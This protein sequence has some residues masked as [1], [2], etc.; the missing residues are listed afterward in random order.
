MSEE[1]QNPEISVS[2]IS[3]SHDKQEILRECE[4]LVIYI[5]R[6]GDVLEN[7]Y[8]KNKGYF[9]HLNSLVSKCQNNDITAE[10]WE[11]LI[12][13]YANTSN[14]TYRQRSVNGRTVLDTL[15]S[16]EGKPGK[17]WDIRRWIPLLFYPRRYERPFT[18][19]L[20]LLLAAFILQYSVGWAGRISDPNLLSSNLQ[21][22]FNLVNDLVPLLLPAVWGGIGSCDFLMKR[23]SD[24]LFNYAYE[25][26]RL[27]GDGTRILLG[28]IF[29]ILVVQIF[30][31][32]NDDNLAI[33]EIGLA[34]MTTAFVTGLGVK[35]VYGAFEAVVEGL[36]KRISGKDSAST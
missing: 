18:A 19:A 31:P 14:F 35:V 23:I 26:A 21:F 27:K 7:E 2:P 30:F 25:E 9:V 32:S 12:E 11:K 13:A 10:E 5:A 4:A 6:H 3:S 28:A 24:K 33:G 29:A 36:S 16:T 1:Q 17:W 34:P 15:G 22:L 20:W 8:E